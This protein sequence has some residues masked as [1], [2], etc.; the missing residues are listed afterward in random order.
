MEYKD[1]HPA[2]Y[3]SFGGRMTFTQSVLWI[4]EF[5]RNNPNSF[6]PI[7]TNMRMY[8]GWTTCQLTKKEF[9]DWFSNGLQKKINRNDNRSW[10][11]L[12]YDYQSKLYHDVRMINEH[13]STRVRHSGCNLLNISEFQKRYPHINTRR[14]EM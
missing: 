7:T 12:S 10:K 8:F 14:T 13:Y 6:I 4:K 11:K 9:E 3:N 2:D 5:F 1:H